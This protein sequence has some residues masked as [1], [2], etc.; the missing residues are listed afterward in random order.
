MVVGVADLTAPYSHGGSDDN[1][2]MIND[3][4]PTQSECVVTIVAGCC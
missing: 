2:L 3:D 1:I 4:S